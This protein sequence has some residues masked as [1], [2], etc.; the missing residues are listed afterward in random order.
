METS[1]LDLRAESAALERSV[2]T[3]VV[4]WPL[5]L[6]TVVLLVTVAI[7]GIVILR[8]QTADYP[9]MRQAFVSA[10]SGGQ[11]TV[12]QALVTGSA[13][14]GLISLVRTGLTL[15]ALLCFAGW[16]ALVTRN[17]PLLGGGTPSR[18]P[19]RVFA[20]ALIPLWNLIKVP[21]ML[22]DLLYRVD[23]EGGGAFMVLAAWM[24]L[25]GSYI[26]S[27]VG[28]WVITWAGVRALVPQFES[29]D[30]GAVVKTFGDVLDQSYRL[31]V[32]V[33]L[34]VAAGTILLAV[35]M[36]RVEARCTDRDR[37]IRA[38]M[39]ASGAPTPPSG[40]SWQGPA[41]H[42]ISPSAATATTATPAAHADQ[43]PALAAGPSAAQAPPAVPLPP[44]PPPDAPRLG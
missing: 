20:Y 44:P 2:R 11:D 28:G 29:G 27:V 43:P 30:M 17:V 39:A 31:G 15:L 35:I 37:E 22:Q 8:L 13:Q 10:L 23:P 40:P 4:S 9:A 38:Q 36:V 16:L 3:Y 21:G 32:V 5:A 19:V 18:G 33:A 42:A 14:L 6:V 26:V 24:G 7:L 1:G 12:D 25:V 41:A 34:M